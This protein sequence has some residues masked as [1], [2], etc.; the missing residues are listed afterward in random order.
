MPK[1]Q[2]PDFPNIEDAVYKTLER[3]L[4]GYEDDDPRMGS[5]F[6]DQIT[7][8]LLPFIRVE[9]I[10]GARMRLSDH[11]I[12]DIDVLAKTRGEAR[13]VSEAISSLLFRYPGMVVVGTRGVKF[14]S[15][16]CLRSPTRAPYDDD[17]VRRYGATYQISV[18][19]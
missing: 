4:P 2:L 7:E 14:D 1:I 15:V 9:R 16:E 3:D 12:V 18:R 6:P 17:T 5:E 19:R 11:P 8:E 13:L 10:G